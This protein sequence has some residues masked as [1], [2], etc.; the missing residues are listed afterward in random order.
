[1]ENIAN[2]ISRFLVAALACGSA[3]VFALA[4][5]ACTTSTSEVTDETVAEA[6]DQAIEEAAG[7]EDDS[8][9]ATNENAVPTVT[10]E[11]TGRTSGSIY[12]SNLWLTTEKTVR[13]VDENGDVVAEETS[14]DGINLSASDLQGAY[15]IESDDLTGFSIQA[16]ATDDEECSIAVDGQIVDSQIA[17]YA[18]C[19]YTMTVG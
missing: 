13:I 16:Y 11:L 5:T 17:E 12:V 9:E 4:L 8:E 19:S 6:L 7:S 3:A 1:M 10:V 15:T 2:L 14:T 18:S